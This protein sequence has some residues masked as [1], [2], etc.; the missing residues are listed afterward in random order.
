MQSSAA[1]GL[2]LLAGSWPCSAGCRQAA[3]CAAAAAAGDGGR[4]W[5]CGGVGEGSGAWACCGASEGAGGGGEVS[6]GC[7]SSCC[8]GGGGGPAAAEGARDTGGGVA[9]GEGASSSWGLTPTASGSGSTAGGATGASAAAA[10]ALRCSEAAAAAACWEVEVGDGS[11]TCSL[12][13]AGRGCL[14]V[15]APEDCAAGW[16]SLPA[17]GAA[18]ARGR[19]AP[20]ACSGSD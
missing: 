14:A 16:E 15:R 10:A 2:Q 3:P 7:G 19:G 4:S 6:M 12:G 20:P 9:A 17:P 18:P 13:G 5:G 1:G 8:E 11:R